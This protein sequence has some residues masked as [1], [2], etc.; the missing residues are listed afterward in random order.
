MIKAIFKI[1]FANP[2]PYHVAHGSSEESTDLKIK[3]FSLQIKF[4]IL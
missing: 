4:L 3:P 2:F 1:P